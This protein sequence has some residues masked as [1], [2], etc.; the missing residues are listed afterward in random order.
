MSNNNNDWNKLGPTEKTIIT[1]IITFS[2]FAGLWIKQDYDYDMFRYE[3]GLKQC[4]FL[5]PGRQEP[6]KI[7]Q[8]DCDKKPQIISEE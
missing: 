8:E 6:I 1:I 5:L 2:I 4:Q 3:K 7:W